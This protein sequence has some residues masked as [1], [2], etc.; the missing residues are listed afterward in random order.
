M[1]A[2]YD[3]LRHREAISVGVADGTAGSFDVRRGHRFG[4]VD[5][6][7]Y[8]VLDDCEPVVLPLPRRRRELVRR[9]YPLPNTAATWAGS[10]YS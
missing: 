6:P 1:N 8:E 2:M 4:R 5:I 3:K 10:R 9:T 7:P